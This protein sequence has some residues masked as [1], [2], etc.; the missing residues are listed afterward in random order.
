MHAAVLDRVLVTFKNT[1]FKIDTTLSVY[2]S[3][4]L[5][6]AKRIPTRKPKLSVNVCHLL[7][8]TIDNISRG[9]FL[10]AVA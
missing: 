2:I 10:S 4:S 3:V 9:G 6:K 5:C 1:L 7:D 8:F